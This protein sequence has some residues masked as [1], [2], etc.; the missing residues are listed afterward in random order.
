MQRMKRF[1][2]L[3]ALVF[4][5]I[6]SFAQSPQKVL[7][8]SKVNK[9]YHESIPAGQAALQQLGNELG[10]HIDTTSDSKHFTE[11]SLRH[12]AAVVFLNTSGNNLLDTSAKAD[13]ER[14]IQAG[15]GFMGIHGAAATE[16]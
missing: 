1:L 3:L 14:Y 11:D 13:F 9:Y 12:Y 10:L 8:F 6:I 4:P 15:G 16:Y 7:V 2:P 5:N